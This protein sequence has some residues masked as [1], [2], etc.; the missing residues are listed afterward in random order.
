MHPLDIRAEDHLRPRRIVEFASAAP[1]M[2]RSTASTAVAPSSGC[3]LCCIAKVIEK[4]GPL[5]SRAKVL[6]LYP[7]G[8][9]VGIDGPVQVAPATLHAHNQR[10]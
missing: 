9:I 2:D 8:G 5:A 1:P 6:K 4:R 10:H 7:D 3:E